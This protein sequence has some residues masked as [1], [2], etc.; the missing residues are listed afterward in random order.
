MRSQTLVR[1]I[2]ALVFVV[3]GGLLSLMGTMGA[4][5]SFWYLICFWTFPLIGLLW[6]WKPDLGAAL[7]IGPLLSLA[8][9]LRYFPGMWEFSKVWASAFAVALLSALALVSLA[10]RGF[11]RWPIPV[12][13]SFLFVTC[14]FATDRLFTNKITVRSHQMYIA[15]DGHAP[16]GDVGDAGTASPV[17][18]YRRVGAGYCYVAFDSSELRRR[19]MPK[20]G[21][22]VVVEYNVFSDFGK[23]RGYNVRSVDGLI[24]ANGELVVR[25][26]ERSGGRILGPGDA[27]SSTDDCP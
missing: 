19:L 15:I 12:S 13:M 11:R 18:L 4:A 3:G 2:G 23:E 9:M 1:L 20:S 16:W 6:F 27:Q 24:L 5:P 10:L 22:E 8:L 21:Q 7:S 17:V 14:A 25:D 26:Y